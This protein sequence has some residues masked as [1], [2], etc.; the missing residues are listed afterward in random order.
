MSRGEGRKE[1]KKEGK[2]GGREEGKKEGREGGREG[3]LETESREGRSQVLGTWSE[4]YPNPFLQSFKWLKYPSFGK[5]FTSS[6]G[7]V[8]L[9]DCLSSRL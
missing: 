5:P 7:K 2:E 6:L 9:L 1:G 4:H 3:G 8:P